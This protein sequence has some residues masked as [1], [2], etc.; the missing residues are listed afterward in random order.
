MARTR[1]RMTFAGDCEA[2]EEPSHYSGGMRRKP[3][4]MS[5]LLGILIAAGCSSGGDGASNTTVPSVT[6]TTAP[7]ETTTIPVTT[8]STAAP[9]AGADLAAKAQAAIIQQADLPTGWKPVAEGDGGLNLEL[10]WSE[11][12]KCLG[13]TAATPTGT[14]TSPTY[15]RGLATQVRSTVE[16]STEASATAISD[17]LSGSKFAACAKDAFQADVKRSAPE[18][19]VPGPVTVA[20]F[21]APPAAPKAIA[22]RVTAEISL[23]EL[24]VPIT[25]DFFVIVQEGTVARMLFLNAGSEFPQDLE[26]SL[27]AKVVARI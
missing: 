10:L 8:A 25:Q 23:A 19:G 14:A 20:S 1:R 9:V 11:L 24:K 15:I 13:V 26:K 17:A 7:A 6:T 5:V 2:A 21:A 22:Y 4:L 3:V 27:I 16:Y 18:G 12:T